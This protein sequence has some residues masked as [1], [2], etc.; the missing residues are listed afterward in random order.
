MARV[1]FAWELGDNFGHLASFAPVA[2]RLVDGVTTATLNSA[3]SPA[4]TGVA[5]KN[6]IVVPSRLLW[7]CCITTSPTPASKKV[8]AKPRL[9]P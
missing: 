4:N 9:A 8:R 3:R 2:Q 5:P 7:Q 6:L 1:L